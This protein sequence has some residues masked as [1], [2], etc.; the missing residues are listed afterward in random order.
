MTSIINDNPMKLLD[1][2]IFSRLTDG[3]RIRQVYICTVTR[4]DNFSLLNIYMAS[5]HLWANQ[6]GHQ[7]SLICFYFSALNLDL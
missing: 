5:R 7:R 2:F 6:C 4:A 3:Q 1:R